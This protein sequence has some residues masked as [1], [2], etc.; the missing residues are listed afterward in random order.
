MTEPLGGPVPAQT[1]VALELGRLSGEIGALRRNIAETRADARA[2]YLDL[3]NES[4]AAHA[5]LCDEI[6]GLRE[7]VGAIRSA[8]AHS[9]EKDS[10]AQRSREAAGHRRHDWKVTAISAA[11]AL[12]AA[13]ELAWATVYFERTSSLPPPPAARDTR[14]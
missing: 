12:L 3:R 2:D 10:Q 14:R 11:V 4:R 7:D 9:A 1:A 6:A 13:L 5:R 8:V